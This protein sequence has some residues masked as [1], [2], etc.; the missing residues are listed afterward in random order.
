M[1][2]DTLDGADAASEA[3]DFAAQIIRQL[4]AD[5]DGVLFDDEESAADDAFAL[6][7]DAARSAR[8][9]GAVPLVLTRAA[10]AAHREMMGTDRLDDTAADEAANRA[11]TEL[12]P[13]AGAQLPA[14]QAHAAR[15]TQY[16]GIAE[17]SNEPIHL[18]LARAMHRF[19]AALG[20]EDAATGSRALFEL[21]S[22]VVHLDACA[23]A[24][25]LAGAAPEPLRVIRPDRFHDYFMHYTALAQK[26]ENAAAEAPVATLTTDGRISAVITADTHPLE[27]AARAVRDMISG[28]ETTRDHVLARI[29]ALL[30][31]MD[32]LRREPRPLI[33]DALNDTTVHLS[34]VIAAATAP[35]HASAGFSEAAISQVARYNQTLL[36]ASAAPAAKAH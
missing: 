14:L 15:L 9:R 13:A 19:C 16:L 2:D 20:E 36:R 5:L 1:T 12:L 3:N 17:Q 7:T 23:N 31:F 8:V 33:G 10:L 35:L 29:R 4:Y 30:D 22:L 24:I 32:K 34:L 28:D 27:A 6:V 11:L 25:D 18:P 21:R 26:P